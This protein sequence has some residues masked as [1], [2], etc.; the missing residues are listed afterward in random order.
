MRLWDW[1][2]FLKGKQTKTNEEVYCLNLSKGKN[3][4][5]L[6]PIILTLFNFLFQ[7]MTK[8][9]SLCTNPEE[10]L[11]SEGRRRQ[12]ELSS[13]YRPPFHITNNILK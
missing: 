5:W 1:I 11:L 7:S 13:T 9:N 3:N 4:S 8:K 12:E 2:E 6:I 10:N